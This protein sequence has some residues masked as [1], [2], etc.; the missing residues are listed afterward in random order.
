MPSPRRASGPRFSADHG[1]PRKRPDVVGSTVRAEPTRRSRGRRA[2]RSSAG[3]ASRLPTAAP[4]PA[5]TWVSR[6][7]PPYMWINRLTPRFGPRRGWGPP[8]FTAAVTQASPAGRIGCAARDAGSSLQAG[9]RARRSDSWRRTE[10]DRA[11][12]RGARAHREPPTHAQCVRTYRCG[13][14]R[15]SSRDDRN[16]GPAPLRRR[17]DRDQGHDGRRRHAL[18]DG[19]GPVRRL[20]ARSRLV[21]HTAHP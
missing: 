9:H 10:L 15:R 14:R 17:P 3:A 13:A 7:L 8:P 4:Q 2:R 19:L 12:H 18:H 6:L 11:G 20:R 21:R 5:S 16:R 1:R